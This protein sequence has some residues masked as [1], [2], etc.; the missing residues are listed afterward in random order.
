MFLVFNVHAHDIIIE[1][2]T[3]L[4]VFRNIT[5]FLVPLLRFCLRYFD[6]DVVICDDDFVFVSGLFIYL[7]IIY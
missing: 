2:E 5:W 4:Y 7:F 3:I 6:D 1:C